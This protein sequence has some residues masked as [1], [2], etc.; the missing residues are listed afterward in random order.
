MR[1]TL[2]IVIALGLSACTSSPEDEAAD[3]L[4]R[5]VELRDHMI[6]LRL[7][8]AASSH[9]D[10]EPHRKALQNAVGAKIVDNCRHAMTQEEV[11][12]ALA[13]GTSESALACTG[14][15]PHHGP[16]LP[17]RTPVQSALTAPTPPSG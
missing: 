15:A 11:K 5:C 3:Q 4:K 7:A 9:I 14:V 13:A 12:C 2:G 8:S 6:D 1:L 17:M 10:I 16:H